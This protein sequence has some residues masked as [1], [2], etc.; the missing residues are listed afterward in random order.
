[1]GPTDGAYCSL[2]PV[3]CGLQPWGRPPGASWQAPGARRRLW[4]PCTSRALVW[5]PA[6]PP[7]VAAGTSTECGIPWNTHDLCTSSA[8]VWPP[9]L[10]PSWN[11]LEYPRFVH[12][13]RTSVAAAARPHARVADSYGC[14]PHKLMGHTRCRRCRQVVY[15]G[16]GLRPGRWRWRSCKGLALGYPSQVVYGGCGLVDGSGGGGLEEVNIKHCFVLSG[17]L[18]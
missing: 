18:Q 15:G 8:L 4:R 16:C 5:P 10:P 14:R 6:L 17:T 3:A 1:V 11:T 12:E 2:Q 13:S 9:A 7:S